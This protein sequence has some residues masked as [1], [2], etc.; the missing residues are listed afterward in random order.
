[1]LTVYFNPGLTLAVC[2]NSSTIAFDVSIYIEVSK[3]IKDVTA[4]PLRAKKFEKAFV[5]ALKVCLKKHS[6]V[7]SFFIECDFTKRQYNILCNLCRYIIHK[8][9]SRIEVLINQSYSIIN[10]AKRGYLREEQ[11]KSVTETCSDDHLQHL[12]NHTA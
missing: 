4:T 11:S 7:L 6:E 8:Y 9:V 2:V 3:T 12:L 1:M 5:G 10:E